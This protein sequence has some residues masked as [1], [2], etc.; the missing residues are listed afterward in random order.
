MCRFFHKSVY[1][2]F[3]KIKSRICLRI[4]FFS[5]DFIQHFSIDFAFQFFISNFFLFNT[6]NFPVGLR[7]CRI[8]LS[9]QTIGFEDFFEPCPS[10]SHREISKDSNAEMTAVL[11][12][13]NLVFPLLPT[14]QTWKGIQKSDVNRLRKT[15]VGLG[16]RFKK[17]YKH[18]YGEGLQVMFTFYVK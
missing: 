6:S 11:P 2:R 7:K 3:L 15:A 12:S 10:S 9:V 4:R 13:A 18:F 16:V 14:G 1:F 5:N 17:C 8:K